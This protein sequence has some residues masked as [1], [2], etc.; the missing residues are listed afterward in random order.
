MVAMRLG[1]FG[2]RIRPL[3]AA[4]SVLAA[5][6]L[7]QFSWA[8]GSCPPP[9]PKGKVTEDFNPGG[10][11]PPEMP[12]NVYSMPGV[13]RDDFLVAWW[14]QGFYNGLPDFERGTSRETDSLVL[15]KYF[16]DQLRKQAQVEAVVG[17]AKDT[18]KQNAHQMLSKLACGQSG[19]FSN[20]GSAIVMGDDDSYSIHLAIGSFSV[21]WQATCQV[22]PKRC[23]VKNAD[24]L[25]GYEETAAYSCKI[26]FTIY[27]NFNF[28]WKTG[29][30]G[31]G[32]LKRINP[33]GW[34]GTSFHQYG[35]WSETIEGTRRR[36]MSAADV[37][38]Y[39]CT[40]P[41]TVTDP[42]PPPPPPVQPPPVTAQ[43]YSASSLGGSGGGA[44]TG[45]VG[46]QAVTLSASTI[47]IVARKFNAVLAITLLV[48]T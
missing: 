24:S 17:P 22:G 10:P 43:K 47:S 6:A 13:L 32:L 9:A 12:G 31:T 29:T 35:R 45:N 4:V 40:K 33:L 2:D 7:P 19:T 23:C 25:S 28:S 41:K 30:G 21:Y 26:D 11:R 42:P 46:E 34:L 3:L 16:I 44:I 36:D 20:R 14:L 48:I 39:C 1:K 8:Q 27:D 38:A 18:L 15:N 37:A 5:C